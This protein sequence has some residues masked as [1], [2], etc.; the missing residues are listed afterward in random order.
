[1]NTENKTSIFSPASGYDK[2]T[3]D[4]AAKSILSYRIVLANILKYSLEEFAG[5]D[6]ENLAD[7]IEANEDN[8]QLA[9]IE[10]I[11]SSHSS[12]VTIK[13]DVKTR[14]SNSN[15]CEVILNVE[16]QNKLYPTVKNKDGK[17]H[18]YSLAKRGMYYVSRMI[19]EQL[20]TGDEDYQKLKKCYSIWIVFNPES[21]EPQVLTYSVKNTSHVGSAIEY[22]Y[23][24]DVDL[25]DLVFIMTDRNGISQDSIH[26][27]IGG[28]FFDRID[29]LKKFIPD[30][31]VY[32]N[33]YREAES[34]CDMRE[35]YLEEG[36]EE[37]SNYNVER[38]SSGKSY[39]EPRSLGRFYVNNV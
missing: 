16:A 22:R 18:A 20:G 5:Y 2:P 19:T 17:Y 10:S 13:F 26:R 31:Q 14:L 25:F 24:Q 32:K 23:N 37:G 34:M 4:A 29:Q 30:N 11:E 39:M 28:L 1:M 38:Y 27:L 21:N 8:P 33:V 35:V 15:G 36:R 7:L 6:A 12:I 3:H 9:K